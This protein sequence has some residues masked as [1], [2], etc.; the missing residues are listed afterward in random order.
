MSTDTPTMI[1]IERRVILLWTRKILRLYGH[2]LYNASYIDT[3]YGN[4]ENE[5]TNVQ[6][7]T[8]NGE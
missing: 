7:S 5:Q 6:L 8:D 1:L 4:K 2:E 3:F